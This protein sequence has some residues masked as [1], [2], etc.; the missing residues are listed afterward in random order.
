MELGIAVLG[1]IINWIG[2]AVNYGT[3]AQNSGGDFWSGFAYGLSHGSIT[4]NSG[5]NNA[6]YI[7][8]EID[9]SSIY[10]Y[11]E[12][13][14]SFV[15]YDYDFYQDDFIKPLEYL[16]YF[17]P[18]IPSEP[19]EPVN[20]SNYLNKYRNSSLN[21]KQAI[22]N[23]FI[24]VAI[25]EKGY[26]EKK[27]NITKYGQWYGDNGQPWCAMFVSWSANQTEI[28]K[29][30]VPRFEGVRAGIA[31]YQAKKRYQTRKSGYTPYAGD[32]IF[33][34][35]IIKRKEQYHT[36]IVVGYDSS[37]ETVY[38]I[39]GNSGDRVVFHS[40]SLEDDYIIG[41]G[42]NGS[43]SFGTIPEDATSGTGVKTR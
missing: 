27:D 5:G 29:T 4:V 24:A 13:S 33:F 32:T 2:N 11:G 36:G 7:D 8:P 1:G 40:Y 41:Y 28:L 16:P 6:N 23:K 14:N 15:G 25:G 43:I 18:E 38:T 26:K 31:W 37:T 12:N 17:F 39:E 30:I 20:S 3:T 22:I 21:P 10:G 42:V 9:F 34:K 19:S 35:R